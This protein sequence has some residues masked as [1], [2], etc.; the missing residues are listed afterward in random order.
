MTELEA[1]KA[2]F[3]RAKQL[4]AADPELEQALQILDQ[5]IKQVEQAEHDP[6]RAILLAEDV[7]R[8]IGIVVVTTYS[9]TMSGF[10]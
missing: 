3:G 9:L 5:L 6:H 4:P 1:L 10:I 8:Q 7:L 2:V